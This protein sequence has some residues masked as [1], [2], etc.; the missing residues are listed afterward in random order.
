M[1]RYIEI[2]S[3]YRDKAT[4]PSPTKFTVNPYQSRGNP[5]NATS[6]H[7]PVTVFNGGLGNDG[8]M[9][10]APL[11][12]L[13]YTGA[14]LTNTTSRFYI[15]AALGV[16]SQEIGYY[17]GAPITLNGF[18]TRIVRYDPVSDGL[19]KVLVNPPIPSGHLVPGTVTGGDIENPSTGEFLYVPGSAH[20]I[21]PGYIV[22]N[23]DTSTT[24]TVESY[25]PNTHLIEFPTAPAGWLP[26]H[27]YV[28]RES[29]PTEVD[30]QITAVPGTN[31]IE[32]DS[33]LSPGQIGTTNIKGWVQSAAD[34]TKTITAPLVNDAYIARDT[35]L[36][37][38]W[39]GAVWQSMGKIK[40]PERVGSYIR[41]TTPGPRFN[42]YAKITAFDP[43]TGEFTI[44]PTPATLLVA[45]DRFE[46]IPPTGNSEHSFSYTGKRLEL[47]CHEIELVNLIIP[48]VA[49][50]DG[51]TIDDY[52]YIYV[53][54]GSGQQTALYSNNP[55]AKR[56]MFRVPIHYDDVN[57]K[58]TSLKSDY[59]VQTS[60]FSFA[61]PV[62]FGLYLPNGKLLDLDLPPVTNPL[63]SS[64]TVEPLEHQVSA[65]FSVRRRMEV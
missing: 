3:D 20:N 40:G 26:T 33:L 28:I 27:H 18:T 59:M 56:M 31:K 1:R 55:H 47:L 65:L 41:I 2:C 57:K 52:P 60:K 54:F 39:D 29:M 53:E 36:L 44:Y 10:T 19:A 25:D 38:K 13:L 62:Y 15:T 12:G 6:R 58:Y 32:V 4:Y 17:I 64:L 30:V 49:M 35:Y 14:G 61:Q 45:G 42:Q 51:S 34:L 16:L 24:A 9:V 21:Y 48:N 5:F 37:Y 23:T 46:I 50:K 8:A 63:G 43:I 7:A 22:E 11:T